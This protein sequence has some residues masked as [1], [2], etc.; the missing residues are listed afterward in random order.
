MDTRPTPSVEVSPK[1]KAGRQWLLIE[2]VSGCLR[3]PIWRSR[4]CRL[5]GLRFNP[6]TIG[7]AAAVYT[8]LALK[9]LPDGAEKPVAG[10]PAKA[11]I[12][13]AAWVPDARHIFFVNT[14]D[15]PRDAGP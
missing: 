8:S 15:E 6:R 14:S 5:A 9:M 3:L 2:H 4:N 13:F 7:R 12:R 1:D 10:L 11:K